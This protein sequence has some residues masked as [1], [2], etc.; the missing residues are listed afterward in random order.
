MRTGATNLHAFMLSAMILAS[1]TAMPG[2]KEKK[3]AQPVAQPTGTSAPAPKFDPSTKEGKP[4]EIIAY[5]PGARDPF[6]SLLKTG[7][8]IDLQKKERRSGVPPLE[9]F[10][11]ASLKVI[12]IVLSPSGNMAMITTPDGK[13][14]TVREGAKIGINNGRIVKIQPDKI[15][16]TEMI[17]NYR[18]EVSP[19]TAY[20]E[21]RKEEER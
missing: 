2:C 18:G 11:I 13:G 4:R 7:K 20:M 5:M 16:V 17:A 12:G 19:Q 1:I 21:L 9:G 14:F 6:K 8:D 10:D 3:A 15:Q